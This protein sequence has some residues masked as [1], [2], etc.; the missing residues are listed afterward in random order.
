MKKTLSEKQKRANRLNLAKW[1]DK[2][3]SFWLLVGAFLVIPF[4]LISIIITFIRTN[5]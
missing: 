3:R 5:N 4:W 2:Q 1:E